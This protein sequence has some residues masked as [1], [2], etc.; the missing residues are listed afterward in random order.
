LSGFTPVFVSPFKKTNKTFASSALK[1]WKIHFPFYQLL[2]QRGAAA[3][4]VV[5]VLET[6]AVLSPVVCNSY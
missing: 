3:A 6:L 4:A 2:L 5:T 1:A